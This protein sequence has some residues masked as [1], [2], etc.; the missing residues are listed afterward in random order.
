MAGA[1][2]LLASGASFP[3]EIEQARQMGFDL[4]SLGLGVPKI[5]RS[6]SVGGPP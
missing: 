5:T 6:R 1:R 4:I 3:I 2:A